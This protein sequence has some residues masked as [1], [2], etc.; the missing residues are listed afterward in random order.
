MP[1]SACDDECTGLLLDDVDS[2]EA[3]IQSLNLSGVILAPYS[4]LISL[5][6][7]THVLQV[8]AQ[9]WSHFWLLLFENIYIYL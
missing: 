8:G 6:N 1:S 3:T 5:D 7:Q 9:S 2:I 4:L